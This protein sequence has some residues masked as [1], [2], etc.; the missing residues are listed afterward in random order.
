MRGDPE[1]EEMAARVGLP[2]GRLISRSKSG[3][4]DLYPDNFVLFNG[5]IADDAGHPLWWGDLDLTRDEAKLVELATALGQRLHLL[6]ESDAR[7]NDPV[8]NAAAAVVIE[9]DGTVALT[10]R[11]GI[12]R[13]G[14][15]RIVR[16]RRPDPSEDSLGG[17][18]S[19]G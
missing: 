5:T 9:P 13:D 12:E 18:G 10:Y 19:H 14:E 11:W 6:F 15:G 4:R 7:F 2:N 16:P 17:S 1:V 3:Y 8:A